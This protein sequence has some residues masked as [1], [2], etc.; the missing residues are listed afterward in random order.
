MPEL[1]QQGR[2]AGQGAV[3]RAQLHGALEHHHPARAD[4]RRAHG[5]RARRLERL[6][7]R[8]H[9]A[10]NGGDVLHLGGVLHA[11][12]RLHHDRDRARIVIRVRVT[13]VRVTSVRV[14]RR[15]RR[16]GGSIHVRVNV[17]LCSSLRLRM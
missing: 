11:A 10:Q 8:R 9:Q 2:A 15:H 4:R 6:A 14:N 1:E 5:R 17:R 12:H 13:S 16:H 3:R 7:G